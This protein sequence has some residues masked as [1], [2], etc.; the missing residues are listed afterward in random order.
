M[1]AAMTGSAVAY[2][3][4]FATDDPVPVEKH[5]WEIYLASI[6]ARDSFGSAGTLPHVDLNYGVTD[7][8]HV[9]AQLPMAFSFPDPGTNQ[10]G[11]G[12]AE[13]G[14]KIR[15]V[16]ETKTQPQIAIYPAIDFA[17]GSANR[18]LG[19]GSTHWFLPVWVQKS[20]GDWDVYGGVGYWRNPGDGNRDYWFSGLV[21]AKQVTK[22]LNLGGEFY[23]T[24]SAA[25]GDPSHTTLDFGGVYD[26]D[27]QHHLMLAL[28]RDLHGGQ[29]LVGYI[30]FQWTFGPGEKK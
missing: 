15:L 22:K 2:G 26:F 19:S 5:H 16:N 10:Y 27:D 7:F 13:I 12:D 25:V 4:P 24:S 17:T 9:H 23:N 8:M 1:I 28:G 3:P 21:A 11:F 29:N 30:A 6:F 20:F 14:A 18:G